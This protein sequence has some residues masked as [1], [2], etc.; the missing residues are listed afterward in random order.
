MLEQIQKAEQALKLEL[1]KTDLT[2]WPVN[3][4]SDAYKLGLFYGIT[5]SWPGD[6]KVIKNQ[7]ET[8]RTIT[9]R[10]AQEKQLKPNYD[11][12]TMAAGGALVV[13]CG[14][15]TPLLEAATQK[16]R[17]QNKPIW[18]VCKEDPELIELAKSA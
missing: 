8:V 1:G 4:A 14:F 17:G 16:A 3:T 5:L 2:V 9:E 10:V 11:G 15:E 7:I 18:I 12:P 13:Y 6:E